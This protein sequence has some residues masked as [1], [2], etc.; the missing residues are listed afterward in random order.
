MAEPMFGLKSIIG[1][2]GRI[3]MFRKLKT[4]APTRNTDQAMV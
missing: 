2:L 4:M 1:M 3:P